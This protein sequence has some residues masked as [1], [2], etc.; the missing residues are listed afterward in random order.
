M[1]DDVPEGSATAILGRLALGTAPLA[2]GLECTGVVDGA[3]AALAHRPTGLLRRA[4]GR[5]VT[6]T[7]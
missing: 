3:A 4:A 7:G 5:G 6:A 2:F 1:A